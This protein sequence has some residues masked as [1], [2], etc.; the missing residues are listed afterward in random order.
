MISDWTTSEILQ[1]TKHQMLYGCFFLREELFRNPKNYLQCC[2]QLI[3][4]FML[5]AS[6]LLNHGK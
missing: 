4:L 5:T 2:Y 3:Y 1:Q 6:S